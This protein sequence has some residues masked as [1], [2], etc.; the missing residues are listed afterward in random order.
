M[1]NK[2]K[3]IAIASVFSF[4][5]SNAVL[6][7]IKMPTDFKTIYWSKIKLTDIIMLG[8]IWVFSTWMFCFIDKQL[9]GLTL[10]NTLSSF[11][12][13]VVFCFIFLA[14]LPFYLSFFPGNISGDS[15]ASIYQAIHRINSTA[16]PVLFTLLVKICVQ[17]GL[18]LFGSMN[19][20]IAVFSLTQMMILV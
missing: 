6:F 20:G 2:K 13:P 14:W 8:L 15:Y 12:L 4:F 17:I 7:S 3:I 16:H 18:Y 9:D 1:E 19:A 11:S 5:F 10:K